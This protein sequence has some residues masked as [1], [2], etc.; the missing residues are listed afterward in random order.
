[1]DSK[2]LFKVWRQQSEAKAM[3]KAREE[4]KA[5]V[6]SAINRLKE[7]RKQL[8]KILSF[9]PTE[10]KS[11]EAWAAAL[12]VGGVTRVEDAVNQAAQAREEA[13]EIL[14]SIGSDELAHKIEDF[15]TRTI[16]RLKEKYYQPCGIRMP[17]CWWKERMDELRE[18][19]ANEDYYWRIEQTEELEYRHAQVEE[20]KS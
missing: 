19:Y 3:E 15:D 7:S 18:I 20:K 12:G 5:R 4:N 17:K 9:C 16:R 11:T 13:Q 6:K 10:S 2:D 14:D 1:M 8:S